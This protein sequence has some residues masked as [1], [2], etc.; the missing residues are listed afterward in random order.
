MG[1]KFD[2][3]QQIMKCWDVT[4]D[5]QTLYEGVCDAE[6]PLSED[7]I[8]NMLM[9]LRG[10]YELK[11]QKLFSL[12]EQSIKE[13]YE[14][15]RELAWFRVAFADAEAKL[16]KLDKKGKKKKEEPPF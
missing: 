10:M 16:N 8:A 14:T 9:G 7:E 11:F 2:L 5:I 1:I 12:F 4:A 3:E 15:E 13:Q 6:P